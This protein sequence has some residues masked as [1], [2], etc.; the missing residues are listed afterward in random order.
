MTKFL[1]ITALVPATGI[2]IAFILL[3][4]GPSE[5]SIAAVQTLQF[6]RLE[7]PTP[8]VPGD[9]IILTARDGTPLT[10]QHFNADTPLQL[11]LLH[12]SGYHGAYLYPLA[13]NLAKTGKAGVYV[14]NLRGHYLSGARR[15]DIDYPD[16]LLDDVTDLIGK[17]RLER[18][19][20]RILIGGHSSGGGLA[21]RYAGSDNGRLAESYLMLAP[22]LGHTA[23]TARKNSGGWAHP[24]TPRII[25]LS[26]LN[27]IGLKNFD[28]LPTLRFN[29][30]ES[31]RNGTETLVYSFR[32]M[33]GFAPHKDLNGDLGKLTG[34]SLFLIGSE[35]EAFDAEAYPPLIKLHSKAEVKILPGLSHFGI[36]NRPEPWAAVSNW[37]DGLGH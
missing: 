34:G 11:I 26:I 23:P 24:A 30:P 16:Q 10:V 22:Y 36:V 5:K 32:L 25:G 15:G 33:N 19:N 17:I 27:A 37:V 28:H 1:I 18:P 13:A 9:R 31:F 4:F 6:D 7:K 2:T 29:M 35:D 12:G 21:L 8:S 14:P 20:A 3:F